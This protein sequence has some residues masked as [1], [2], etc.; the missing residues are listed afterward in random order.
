MKLVVVDKLWHVRG[1]GKKTSCGLLLIGRMFEAWLGTSSPE[2]VERLLGMITSEHHKS[3]AD[4]K[5]CPGC[6]EKLDRAP[7]AYYARQS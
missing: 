5:P 4:V 2:K 1:E 7:P 6:W 3:L